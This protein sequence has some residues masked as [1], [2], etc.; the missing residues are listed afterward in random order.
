MLSNLCKINYIDL[1]LGLCLTYIDRVDFHDSLIDTLIGNGVELLVA[2][3]SDP[4]AGWI[5]DVSSSL[6]VPMSTYVW[7][8]CNVQ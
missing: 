5:M 1:L 6:Q 2:Q 3:L 7:N 4:S 8:Q